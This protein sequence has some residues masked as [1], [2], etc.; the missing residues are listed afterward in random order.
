MKHRVASIVLAVTLFIGV[1][2]GTNLRIEADKASNRADICAIVNGV[3]NAVDK[4]SS[5][6]AKHPL[7]SDPNAPAVIKD[8]ADGILAQVNANAQHNGR[9]TSHELARLPKCPS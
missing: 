7:K 2:I 8:V 6:S 1:T 5:Y 9:T 4:N 3:K